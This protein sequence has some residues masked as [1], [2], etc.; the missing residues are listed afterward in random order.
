MNERQTRECP[1]RRRAAGTRFYP[2][3]VSRPGLEIKLNGE[4]YDPWVAEGRH[5][6]DSTTVRKTRRGQA[7]QL[8]SDRSAGA[9]SSE[10]RVVEYIEGLSSKL[11]SNGMPLTAKTE[12]LGHREI[13]ALGRRSVNG[14]A[15]CVARNVNHSGRAV[16]SLSNEA[17]AIKPL[18][19]GVRCV[20]IGIAKKR[21]PSTGRDRRSKADACR[22]I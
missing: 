18:I 11:K 4:L 6:A 3:P 8:I 5:G 16:G 10:V 12:V 22:I 14:A 9:E 13:D 19:Y 2:G 21:W 20:G 7:A 15:L 1:Q 17:R